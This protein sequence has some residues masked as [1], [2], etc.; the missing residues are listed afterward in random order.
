MNPQMT[1][2]LLFTFTTQMKFM[3]G[4]LKS[5]AIITTTYLKIL[6]CHQHLRDIETA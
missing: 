3:I 1:L 2:K 4:A 5:Q 6:L